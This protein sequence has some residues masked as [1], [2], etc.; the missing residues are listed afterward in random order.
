MITSCEKCGGLKADPGEMYAGRGCSCATEQP[1][2]PAVGLHGV[3]VPLPSAIP[4][5]VCIGS[6]QTWWPDAPPIVA[7]ELRQ[8]LFELMRKY[9]VTTPEEK[10][11]NASS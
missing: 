5:R 4:I 6:L 1:V 10:R 9:P 2:T 3:V 7:E 8:C 11:H